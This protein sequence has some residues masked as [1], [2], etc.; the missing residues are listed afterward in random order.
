[1]KLYIVLISLQV[2]ILLQHV[3]F[4]VHLVVSGASPSSRCATIGWTVM[5][6]RMR[7]IVVSTASPYIFI[8][9]IL[10]VFQSVI[11]V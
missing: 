9:I 4:N 7:R 5:E 1:V 3:T 6:A 10:L 8:I 2:Q 11:N